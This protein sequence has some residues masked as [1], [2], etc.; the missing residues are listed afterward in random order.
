M[1]RYGRGDYMVLYT[2]NIYGPPHKHIVFIIRRLYNWRWQE[3]PASISPWCLFA[4]C[5][6]L[7][8]GRQ[9][10]RSSSMKA[11]SLCS[12]IPT[13]AINSSLNRY[14]F[15]FSLLLKHKKRII[16]RQRRYLY[17]YNPI[18]V[19]DL[20][21]SSQFRKTPINSSVLLKSYFEL[22]LCAMS[23]NRKCLTGIG[24]LHAL[25]VRETKERR[26]SVATPKKSG[27]GPLHRSASRIYLWVNIVG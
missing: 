17:M 4:P 11:K 7:Q 23:Y 3:W 10:K 6:R 13:V 15:C 25:C 5:D 14:P 19:I 22:C 16:C 12:A 1:E 2:Q 9:A 21:T 24:F 27:K 26:S 18:L 8:F 20:K